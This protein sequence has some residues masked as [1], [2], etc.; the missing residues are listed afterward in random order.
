MLTDNSRSFKSNST[1]S[2]VNNRLPVKRYCMFRMSEL[3]NYT[4]KSFNSHLDSNVSP[5]LCACRWKISSG[6]W[7]RD[8]GT[9]KRRNSKWRWW[10][11]ATRERWTHFKKLFRSDAP[12]HDLAFFRSLSGNVTMICLVK[13]LY[14]SLDFFCAVYRG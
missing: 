12:P 9:S 1:M 4:F 6:K 11:S 5:M 8:S 10:N 3:M 2:S 13:A 14:M 7:S